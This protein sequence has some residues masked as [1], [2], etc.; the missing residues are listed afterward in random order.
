PLNT[1]TYMVVTFS[2]TADVSTMY[3][4]AVAQTV[5]S[6][7]TLPTTIT[8]TTDTKFVAMGRDPAVNYVKGSFDELRI[9]DIVRSPG[10]ITTEYNNQNSPATFLSVGGR[11][12][13]DTMS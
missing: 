1:W 11:Q 7:G 10:W 3:K 6:W 8:S 2:T 9:S 12:T 13:V 4:N 5:T